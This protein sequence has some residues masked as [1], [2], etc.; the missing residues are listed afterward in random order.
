MAIR[1]AVVGA[2]HLGK[3]HARLLAG[4]DGVE[5]VAIT[6]PS[7]AA[8]AA[9]AEQFQI[10]TYASHSQVVDKVDAAI[11]ASPTDLHANIARDFLLAGKH[12]L[13]EKPLTI[14]AI[15][16][17]SL[18]DLA[19]RK[20]LVL[21]VGHVERFNPA[22]VAAA[23][24]TA[25]PK[26]ID[27]T[28]ASSFPGRCL[29]VGVVMDLMIHDIDLVLSLTEADLVDV[30]AS[31]LSVISDHEDL[32]EAR[33]TFACGLIAQL[34]ASRV[35]LTAART[36]QVYGEHGFAEL[37]FSGPKA[38][39]V[40]PSHSVCQR[41]LDLGSLGEPKSM[42]DKIFADHL[43]I[44]SPTLESRNAILDE[45]HDF[46]ISI[47]SGEEPTVSGAAGARAVDVASQILQAIAQ[48]QWNGNKDLVNRGAH[49]M[50][51]ERIGRYRKSA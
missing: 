30:Q 18:V 19:R 28:R 12:L 32:A 16:A 34:R 38:T 6:D 44:E 4:I 46:V 14:A 7:D 3:I 10:P 29:D 39:L 42:R 50:P 41:T 8:R 51:P 40:R 24:V 43:Q 36:M 15:D 21:Q 1:F 11:I 48:H 22:W 45:L 49:A 23:D 26:Y 5:V 31:G 9:V 20:D 27:A 47:Q 33:L 35:S 13:V 17:D 37:D 2:G 25:H